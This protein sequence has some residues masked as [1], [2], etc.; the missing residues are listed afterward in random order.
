MQ[1]YGLTKNDLTNATLERLRGPVDWDDATGG[2]TSNHFASPLAGLRGQTLLGSSFYILLATLIMYFFVLMIELIIPAD[3]HAVR[4][5]APPTPPEPAKPPGILD[6]LGLQVN[7]TDT[8]ASVGCLSRLYHLR[9]CVRRPVHKRSPRPRAP[10][11]HP[12]TQRPR[13]ET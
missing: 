4:P 3:K 1:M 5:P 11:L 2:T 12:R 7:F 13:M 6:N 8:H 9:L 10:V